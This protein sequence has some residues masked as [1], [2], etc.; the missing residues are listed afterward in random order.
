MN[1]NPINLYYTRAEY[2]D[3]EQS[4]EFVC[5][6]IVEQYEKLKNDLNILSIIIW[7]EEVYFSVSLDIRLEIFSFLL[8]GRWCS[9][10]DNWD[11]Y[12]FAP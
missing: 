2:E 12:P 10:R 3:T 5:I 11:N 7:V 8:E 4:V 1:I 6:I 9:H